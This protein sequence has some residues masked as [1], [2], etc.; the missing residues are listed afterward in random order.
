MIIRT[1]TLFPRVGKVLNWVR[2]KSFNCSVNVKSSPDEVEDGKCQWSFGK[3]KS[4]QISYVDVA[5]RYF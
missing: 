4:P 1:N 3:L 2:K 5:G